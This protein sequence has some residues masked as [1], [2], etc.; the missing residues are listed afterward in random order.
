MFGFRTVFGFHPLPESRPLLVFALRA[1]TVLPMFSDRHSPRDAYPR[2]QSSALTWLLAALIGAFALELVLLSPWFNASGQLQQGLAVS[3]AGL[4]SGRVWTVV[5]YWLLHSPTNLFHVGF[6]LAGLYAFGRELEPL[7]GVRRFVG[8]FAGSIVLGGLFWAAVNW[9][10]DGLLIGGTAGVCGLLALYAA[11]YPNREFSFLLLFFFPVT[12]RPKHLALGL[13]VIDLFAFGFYE[14]LGNPPPFAYAPSAHLGGMMAGWIYYRFI[15]ES[16]WRPF[17]RPVA[18]APTPWLNRARPAEPITPPAPDASSR[19][20]NLRADV[21]RVLDKI[22]SH[23]FA[24]LSVDER[25]VL[26]EAKDLLSRR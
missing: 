17:G 12:L 18:A 8:V 1:A 6:V 2:E 23:G 20:A 4:D 26:D 3:P 11:L 25:R 21:D 7:L 9:R 14:I 15:H 13:L 5:T 22:N 16:E 19:R 24:S 10:H